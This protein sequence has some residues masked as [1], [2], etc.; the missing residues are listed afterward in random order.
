[1]KVFVDANIMIDVISN[2]KPFVEDSSNIINLATEGGF[3]LYASSLSFVNTLYIS[4]KDVGKEEAFKKLKLLHKVLKASP[5]DQD[6]LD[7]AIA[8]DNKD[9][10]DNL[11]YC[12]AVAAGCEVIVTRNVKDFPADGEVKAMLPGDYLDSLVEDS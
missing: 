2:R 9:F 6:E 5:M 3:E 11:Q 1:M 4:R 8:M 10:E 12:S 7:A